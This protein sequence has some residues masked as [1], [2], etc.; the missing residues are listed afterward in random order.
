MYTTS[1]MTNRGATLDHADQ[2]KPSL[3]RAS[4]IYHEDPLDDS[5]DKLPDDIVKVTLEDCHGPA[6]EAAKQRVREQRNR[7]KTQ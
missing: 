6:I 3:R 5:L 1:R 7:L 4:Q 2:P